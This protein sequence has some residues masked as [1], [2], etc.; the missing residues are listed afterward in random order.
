[1]I[2]LS[3][4]LNSSPSFSIPLSVFFILCLSSLILELSLVLT[5]L[6]HSL[7]ISLVL[8]LSFASLPLSVLLTLSS[9]SLSVAPVSL[10]LHLSLR[11]APP[12][13]T[14]CS[15]LPLKSFHSSWVCFPLSDGG[16]IGLCR[17]YFFLLF[18]W[19]RL[20]VDPCV[21]VTI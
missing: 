4:S 6:P 7:S 3:F 13:A 17:C 14:E 18:I 10:S 16:L 9:I 11:R 1:M 5:H 21:F 20:F 8:S 15:L 12:T 2:H 19:W